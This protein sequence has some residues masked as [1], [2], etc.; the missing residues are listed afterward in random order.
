MVDDLKHASK[1]KND[2]LVHLFYKKMAEPKS[3]P[4]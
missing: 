2:F 1:Y 3:L 4:F